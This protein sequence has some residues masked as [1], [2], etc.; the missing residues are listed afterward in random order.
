MRL[1]PLFLALLAVSACARK[2]A[3]G[4]AA[5]KVPADPAAASGLAAPRAFADVT[6][7]VEE[8]FDAADYTYMRLRTPQ[9]EVWAAVGKSAVK[10]GA[11]VTVANAMPMDGFESKTLNRKFDRIVFGTLGEPGAPASAENPHAAPGSAPMAS[12]HGP[13]DDR[14][15]LEEVMAQHASAAKGPE[16]VGKIDVK[17]AEGPD[18]KSVAEL[19]AGKAALKGKEVA[20][21]GKVVK[22]TPGVMGKNWIHLRD[23]SGSRAEKN[24]DVTVTTSET[25]ALGDV[26]L[27]RGTVR[28]DVDLGSGYAYPVLIEN[29]TLAK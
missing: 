22:Y 23:G 24:D 3:P 5:A 4:P 9:G 16:N 25:T 19:F 21:R 8:T 2:E 11:T 29:A 13:A 6:G 26:V 27:V 28:L 15:A 1:L 7:V 12:G 18:G 17:K 14:K 10:K 20:V